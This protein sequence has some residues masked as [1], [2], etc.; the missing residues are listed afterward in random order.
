VKKTR[1]NK[2]PEHDPE[3]GDTGFPPDQI[4]IVAASAVTRWLENALIDRVGWPVWCG[5]GSCHVQA[6]D[7]YHGCHRHGSRPERLHQMRADLGRLD[8]VAEILQI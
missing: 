5:V 6:F 7:D 3:K 8:A 4:R 2:N 1:Q